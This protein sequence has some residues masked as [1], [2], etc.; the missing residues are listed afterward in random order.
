MTEEEANVLE[1]MEESGVF[2]ETDG[3]TEGEELGDSDLEDEE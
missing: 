3:E 1:I 2:D